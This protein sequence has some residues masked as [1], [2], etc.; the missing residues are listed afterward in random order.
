LEQVVGDLLVEQQ[1]TLAVAE[2]CT[3][4]LLGTRITQVPGASRYF[5]GGVI[6]YSNEIKITRL[7]VPRETVDRFGA[8]S[9]ETAASMAVGAARVLGAD[10]GVAITGV[11]G[12]TGGSAEKPVGTVF[13]GLAA[14]DRE[15]VRKF[16]MGTDRHIVRERSAAAALEMIRR[17][18]LGLSNG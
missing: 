14:G 10:I 17:E 1:K 15:T 7:G 18:L 12:P 8:V 6:A 13:I 11:A 9:A 2:S 5:V 3:G 4:G 16:S